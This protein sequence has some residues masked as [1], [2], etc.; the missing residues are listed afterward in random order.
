MDFFVAAAPLLLAVLLIIVAGQSALRAGAVGLLSA[1]AIVT[2]FDPFVLGLGDIVHSLIGGVLTTS[3]VSYVLLGG[4]I[5]YHVLREGGALEVLSTFVLR[6]IPDRGH[7]VLAL[8]FGVSVFFESATGFGVGIIVVAPLFMALGFEPMRAAL[9]A[10]LGQCA[11]PWGALAIGT[12]LGSD[13]SG[14]SAERLGALAVPL[15]APYVL[16]TG[17]AALYIAKEWHPIGPRLLLLL[18]YCAT[19]LALL[20]TFNEFVAVELAGCLTGI[21]VV[22]L[23]GMFGS[24]SNVADGDCPRVATQSLLR[25]FAPVAL[26]LFGLLITRLVPGVRRVV[27][28]FAAIS[29]ESFGFTLAPLYHSGFWLLLAALAGITTFSLSGRL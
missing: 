4:V 9:L 2:F 12:L 3:T 10:L 23:A 26:L 24:R 11:V 5:F 7:A 19:F 29:F 18:V 17:V 22:V 1:C 8:V 27:E 20:W 6:I 16:A 15:G 13:L 25:S 14:V 28:G 21:A